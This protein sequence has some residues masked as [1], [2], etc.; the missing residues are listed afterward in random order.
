MR[1]ITLHQPFATLMFLKVNGR[2]LKSNETRSWRH[3]NVTGTIGIAAAAKMHK[4]A[5]DLMLT[6]PFCED[7]KGIHLPL[8]AILGTL[9]IVNYQRS[10]DWMD[11]FSNPNMTPE[12]IWVAEREFKYGDYSPKR[13][14]WKTE[15]QVAFDQPIKAKGSQGW[16]SYQIP[17]MHARTG[18]YLLF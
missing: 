9:D 14:I 13:W 2:V 15:N 10:E 3:E 8:G 16:W 5:I 1:V 6:W 12:Q 7:L 4:Y 18:Q 17:K 11:E